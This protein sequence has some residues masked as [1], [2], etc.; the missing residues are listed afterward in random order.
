MYDKN[1]LGKASSYKL[2]RNIHGLEKGI[3]MKD[4]KDQRKTFALNY[5]EDT[6]YSYATLLKDPQAVASNL[7]ELIWAHDVLRKYFE[8]V[9][10]HPV[11][12]KARVVFEKTGDLTQFDDTQ[13][14][15]EQKDLKRRSVDYD[16][17]LSLARNRKSIRWFQQKPVPRELIDKAILLSSYSPSACNRQPYFY[18]IIENPKRI[19]KISDITL[20]T[21]GWG[22]NIPVLAA[23]VGELRAYFNERDRHLIYIDASLSVMGFMYALETFGIGTC[24]INWADIKAKEEEISKII[25]LEEDQRIVMFVALGY[26]DPDGLVANSSRKEIDLLRRYHH[27]GEN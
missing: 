1:L 15:Y 14:P 23:V 12:E 24:G 2:R 27:R 25:Q 8:I 3:L 17:L 26:P 22:D 16:E 4:Q 13:V 11:S 6:V 10:P 7:N 20:G 5:I 9:D 18:E 21:K 19:N